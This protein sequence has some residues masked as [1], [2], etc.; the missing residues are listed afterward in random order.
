MPLKD[1]ALVDRQ[2][3]AIYAKANTENYDLMILMLEALR[4]KKCSAKRAEELHIKDTNSLG[5]EDN[6]RMKRQ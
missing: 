6:H 3:K 1:H 5:A 2:K 4:T